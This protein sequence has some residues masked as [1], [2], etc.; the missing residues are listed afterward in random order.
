MRAVS[1]C[2]KTLQGDGIKL[3]FLC[4]KADP[5][6]EQIHQLNHFFHPLLFLSLLD[7]DLGDMKRIRF[8]ESVCI[9]VVSTMLKPNKKNKET[10]KIYM[11]KHDNSE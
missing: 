5:D 4:E 9:Y 2:I 7:W 10:M 8:T 6:G 1:H 11:I 3:L